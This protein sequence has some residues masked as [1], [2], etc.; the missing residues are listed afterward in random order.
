MFF[1]TLTTG[2]ISILVI[3]FPSSTSKFMTHVELDLLPEFTTSI[4][5]ISAPIERDVTFTCNVK[6]I[7]QFK[8]GWVKADTKAIQ[9]IGEQII[10]HNQRVSVSGDFV[11]TFNL[12]IREV[13]MDDAGNYMCQINTDPMTYQSA[14][15]NVMVPPD[16]DMAHTSG[17]IVAREHEDTARL[18]CT[19]KGVPRPR[20]VWRREGGVKIR[21]K[22]SQHQHRTQH[23]L[24]DTWNSDTL[25]IHR[26]RRE[27]M[28]AYLCI[29]NNDVPPAVSRRI[30]LHVQFPPSILPGLSV[31]GSAA[32]NP[33]TLECIVESYPKSF[34][35]WSI[36]DKILHGGEPDYTV[37]ELPLS[38]YRISSKLTLKNYNADQAGIYMCRGTNSLGQAESTTRVYTTEVEE[39]IPR[40]EPK[41]EIILESEEKVTLVK[42]IAEPVENEDRW[43]VPD[44]AGKDASISEKQRKHG[45]RRKQHENQTKKRRIGLLNSRA[46]NTFWNLHWSLFFLLY[47]SAL[48][49]KQ[50]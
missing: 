50:I 5:N 21:V 8:V 29:A 6:D 38:M 27:D 20:I 19:A 46:S 10:T 49:F 30:Y 37:T 4:K 31:L 23:R 18:V 2:A 34:V 45:G 15:L 43:T 11:T 28:G 17:D 14:W 42:E 39:L 16:I 35:V 44:N 25:E 33:L 9:A 22:N 1:S 12:H 13:T 24:V 48:L 32:G 47:C 26:V 41:Y 3:S 36:G 7:G 40:R